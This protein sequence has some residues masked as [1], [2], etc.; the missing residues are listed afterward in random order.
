MHGSGDDTGGVERGVGE[1]EGGDD[2]VAA[3]FGGAEVDEEDLVFVVM[4]DAGEFGAAANEVAGGE[5]AFEDGVLE[6]VAEAAHRFED[7]AEAFVVGDV[8]A[9]EVGLAHLVTLAEMRSGGVCRYNGSI[10]LGSNRF[11]STS[12]GK[13]TAGFWRRYLICPESWLTMR[14]RKARYAELSR[15]PCR[16]SPT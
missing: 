5:L 6:V 14:L 11:E 1:A 15:L 8:V 4:D 7:F 12:T 13:R 16:F 9:D 3:A 10:C 2:A